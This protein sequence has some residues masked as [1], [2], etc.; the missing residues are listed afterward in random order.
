MIEFAAP[1]ALAR[2]IKLPAL[3]LEIVAAQPVVLVKEEAEVMMSGDSE[4]N[5]TAVA[6]ALGFFELV[7]LSH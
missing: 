3:E 7:I 1:R 6:T 4:A 2:I 5:V